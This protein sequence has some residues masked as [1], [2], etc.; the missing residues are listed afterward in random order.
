MGQI[1]VVLR[2]NRTNAPCSFPAMD[3]ISAYHFQVQYRTVRSELPRIFE[4]ARWSHQCM[5]LAVGTVPAECPCPLVL[6]QADA[7]VR[8]FID[9][10]TRTRTL[11]RRR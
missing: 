4:A 3:S 11:W 10:A 2:K 5:R 7:A 6:D 8:C 9:T 1:Y